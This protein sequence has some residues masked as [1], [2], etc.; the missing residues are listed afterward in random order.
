M[1]AD[2]GPP[3][4][5][6]VLDDA[7]QERAAEPDIIPQY[8]VLSYGA[9]FDV[10]GLVSRMD[11]ADIEIPAFQRGFVWDFRR[12][13]RFVESLLLGLP[14]PGIFLWRNPQTQRLVVID[15][16]QRLRTLQ[17]FY[18]GT[19]LNRVFSIPRKLSPYQ[20][21]APRFVGKTYRKL[22][23]EDKRLLD[24]SIIHATI[25]NQERPPD[26]YSSVFYLFERLNT[27]GLPLQPQE[28]RTAVYQGEFV[29]FLEQLNQF[30]SWR[31]VYG[32]SSPR[33][34][35]RELI[36]RFF[37][38]F[39]RL[40]DYSRP[41]KEFLNRFLLNNKSL[42]RYPAA[43]LQD[44]FCPTIDLVAHQLGKSAF[45]TGPALNAAIFDAVMVGLAKRVQLRPLAQPTAIAKAYSNLL[46][47]DDFRNA[48]SKATAD[49]K[50]V[51]SRVKLAI[52]AFAHLP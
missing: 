45:R 50:S 4:P 52:D 42:D 49:E 22:D 51:S 13:A 32:K 46:S 36:L 18:H 34:K 43:T 27:E 20:L 35:D 8:S 15:G 38:M 33:M 28:I 2:L 16:Q 41:M 25:V 14:V 19:I 31:A 48:T 3:E 7:E 24:N 47:L 6:Q 29:S 44:A 26:D 39:F 23:A 21:V 17:G 12:A 11:N 5:V 9:D 40:D 1:S 37:A 30:A 10:A